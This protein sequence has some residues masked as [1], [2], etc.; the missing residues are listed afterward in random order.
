LETAGVDVRL[1][2]V[3]GPEDVAD[4]ERI[5]VATGARPFDP[6]LPW[7][8]SQVVLTAWDALERPQDVAGPVLILDWG[9]GWT[10]LDAAE[11]L[12]LRNLPVTL[13]T[14]G[15]MVGEAVHQYQRNRYLGRLDALGVELRTGV[16]VADHGGAV[17]LRHVFSGR[18]MPLGTWGTIV[19]EQGR[20]P[21]DDLWLALSDDPRAVRVGDVLGPRGLEEAVAEGYALP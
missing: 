14:A 19:L 17:V 18:T 10:G 13:A 20:V 9:G 15:P 12:A 4:C 21:D 11:A 2:V 8:S 16:E 5:I 3:A 1:G 6:M 7:N